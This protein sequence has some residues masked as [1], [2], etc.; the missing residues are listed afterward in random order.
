MSTLRPC[1]A[2]GAASRRTE[3]ERHCHWARER[4]P[5]GALWRR[6]AAEGAASRKERSEA[7]RSEV[8]ATE[9]G[10]HRSGR[11]GRAKPGRTA[12]KP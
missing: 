11:A 7:Q 4:T 2:E 5:G 3:S 8:G 1:A 9:R 12:Q 6:C 10:S